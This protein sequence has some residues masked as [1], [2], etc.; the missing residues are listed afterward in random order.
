MFW[1]P[2][3]H[4]NY[5]YHECGTCLPKSTGGLTSDG[6]NGDFVD[7]DSSRDA[8]APDIAS[9]LVASREAAWGQIDLKCESKWWTWDDGVARPEPSSTA[10][11]GSRRISDEHRFHNWIA[12]EQSAP[13]WW[14]KVKAKKNKRQ[15]AATLHSCASQ[16]CCSRDHLNATTPRS[17]IGSLWPRH[18]K[19][20]AVSQQKPCSK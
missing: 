15:G 3:Q 8:G 10:S 14:I 9:S 16:S 11:N 1:S 18:H 7:H 17:L 2:D 20:A 19:E 13:S 6:P 5:S 4:R 12:D